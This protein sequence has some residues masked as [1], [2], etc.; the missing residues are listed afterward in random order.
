MIKDLFY[1]SSSPSIVACSH[2]SGGTMNS[3][4]YSRFTLSSA[5]VSSAQTYQMPIGSS[6][7]LQCRGVYSSD[8]DY[9]YGIL[10]DSS[11]SSSPKNYLVK[12][13]T[14]NSAAWSLVSLTFMQQMSGNTLNAVRYGK[15]Y[16]DTE[17]YYVGGAK[18]VYSPNFSG[19]ARTYPAGYVMTTT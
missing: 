18:Q 4:L 3:L 7:K 8:S 19:T 5:T 14:Q 13:N 16:S 12:I 10:D 17:A 11:S 9:L 15:F 2:L 1:E 6:S